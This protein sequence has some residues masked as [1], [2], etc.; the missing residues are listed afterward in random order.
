MKTTVVPEN[1][2]APSLANGQSSGISL[3]LLVNQ[4]LSHSM[5][6]AFRSKSLVVN[7]VS[8]DLKLDKGRIKVAPV[9]RDLLATVVTNARNGDIC[10]SADKFRDIITL[11]VQERNNYNGYALAYSIRAMESE[12]A[13]VGGS[14]AINGEQKKVVTISFSFPNQEEASQYEC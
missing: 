6:T 10:I 7:G 14:I 11:Q 1:D 8:R 2:S 13:N 5:P 9:I 3:Q 4:L 12:A